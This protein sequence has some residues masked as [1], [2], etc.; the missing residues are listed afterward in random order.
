[1]R[2][3]GGLEGEKGRGKLYSEILIEIHKIIKHLKA[4]HLDI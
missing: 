3:E 1:M 2:L 4:Y